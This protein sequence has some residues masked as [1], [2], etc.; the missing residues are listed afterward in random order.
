MTVPIVVRDLTVSYRK[1]S[2]VLDGIDLTV[3]AGEV[4]ALLGPNGAGK[5]TLLR[6]LVRLIE[7][8]KG[9]IR[10]GETAVTA[11]RGQ[12]LRRLRTNVGFVFQRFNLVQRLSAFHNVLHGTLGRA[13]LR[14]AWPALASEEH[15]G[16]AMACLDRVGLAD[17]AARRVDTL[18]GGQQ[19][20]V[21]IARMLAQRPT[22]VLADEPVASLDP[23]SGTAVLDLLRDIAAE[24]RL[25]VLVTLHQL[26]YARRYADRVVGL[27]GGQLVMD[28]AAAECQGEALDRLFAR[29]DA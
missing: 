23:A 20:R 22:V 9:E 18:S 26:D 13:G 21:A 27:R 24:Q 15:R 10:I 19:Q 29:A 14:A 7:P 6:C 8:A 2:V 25:T 5:S 4:V 1:G 11:A 17:L 12:E 16:T 3:G 28:R